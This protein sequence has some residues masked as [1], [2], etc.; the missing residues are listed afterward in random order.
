[1]QSQPRQSLASQRPN[2]VMNCAE[3]FQRYKFILSL[4]NLS[5]SNVI[6]MNLQF[7]AILRVMFPRL[8]HQLS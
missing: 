2:P 5:L 3:G 4:R 8:E 7:L 6:V 1:M